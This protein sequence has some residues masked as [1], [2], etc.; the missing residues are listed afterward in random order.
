M[1][2]DA[3]RGLEQH[4]PTAGMSGAGTAM[5]D[6]CYRLRPMAV[7]V[8]LDTQQWGKISRIFEIAQ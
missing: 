7:K 8:T 6:S 2:P 1:V 4:W 5:A 3:L